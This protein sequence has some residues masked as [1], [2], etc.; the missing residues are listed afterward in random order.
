MSINEP[1]MSVVRCALVLLLA[2]TPA[3]AEGQDPPDLRLPDFDLAVK[4]FAENMTKQQD[5]EAARRREQFY[6]IGAWG[7]ETWWALLLGGGA[8][9]AAAGG[10][11]TRAKSRPVASRKARPVL[12]VTGGIL[13]CAGAG[14]YFFGMSSR[15]HPSLPFPLLPFAAVG[16]GVVGLVFLVLGAPLSV[17]D[18]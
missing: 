4:Q 11:A 7:R 12:L 16:V 14:L 1:P 9:A 15:D 8:A 2:A 10:A 5:A 3:R 18:E 13:V 17:V 6:G